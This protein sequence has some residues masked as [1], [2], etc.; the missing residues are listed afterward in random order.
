MAL[1]RGGLVRKKK[2]TSER[3]SLEKRRGRGTQREV[4]WHQDGVL[5][6]EV[7]TLGGWEGQGTHAGDGD[8]GSSSSP[9]VLC[10]VSSG[11]SVLALGGVVAEVR[12]HQC[13]IVGKDDAGHTA[14][15]EARLTWRRARVTF[16]SG[17]S[18]GRYGKGDGHGYEGE[19][20]EDATHQGMERNGATD[21]LTCYS[22]G[23]KGATQVGEAPP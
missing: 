7:W 21:D 19:R 10:R 17:V 11:L 8:A 20:R 18:G 15:H 5:K 13:R 22:P 23:D 1:L 3:H 4:E 14:E 9:S 2:K 16:G 6:I 12:V